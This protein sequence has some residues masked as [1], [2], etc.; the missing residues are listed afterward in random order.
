MKTARIQSF[1]SI[2]FFRPKY[3]KSKTWN[4]P[5][6]EK[7]QHQQR[8]FDVTFY[9]SQQNARLHCSFHA[10]VF[11]DRRNCVPINWNKR[12]V[13]GEHKH[14]FSDH[15]IISKSNIGK[16]M[17]K[18]ASLKLW[19]EYKEND[20]EWEKNNERERWWSEADRK[21]F[22]WEREKELNSSTYP[23]QCM[24]IVYKNFICDRGCEILDEFFPLNWY[25]TQKYFNVS[26]SLSDSNLSFSRVFYLALS[27]YFAISKIQPIV[28]IIVA[29][30]FDRMENLLSFS[31]SFSL[32]FCWSWLHVVRE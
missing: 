7:Q 14:C 6:T 21:G 30:R 2:E 31:V 17:G 32:S 23:G 12:S 1:N 29:E 20:T 27:C 26:L 25:P 18:L 24:R 13:G 9:A 19:P 4:G 5:H 8:Q 11:A 10:V 28:I 3:C 15:Q 16:P 22:V